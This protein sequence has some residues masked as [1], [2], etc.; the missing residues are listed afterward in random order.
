MLVVAQVFSLGSTLPC[1]CSLRRRRAPEVLGMLPRLHS[2]H[3]PVSTKDRTR[4]GALKKLP[5]GTFV[6]SP[7]GVPGRPCRRALRRLCGV[8]EGA[9]RLSRQAQ[10]YGGSGVPSDMSWHRPRFQTL[11]CR[12]VFY[13]S[14][15][16]ALRRSRQDLSSQHLTLCK[17][18]GRRLPGTA[19]R[20]TRQSVSWAMTRRSQ[21]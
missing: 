13:M 7:C 14:D 5:R 17:A 19:S 4:I 20:R 6:G 21:S 10:L 16:E 2:S 3:L 18:H 11:D 9:G 12:N 8:R 15:S 1:S